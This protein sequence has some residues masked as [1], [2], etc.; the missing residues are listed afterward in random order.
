MEK[1]ILLVK[2]ISNNRGALKSMVITLSVD[3]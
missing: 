1:T 3:Q 2:G